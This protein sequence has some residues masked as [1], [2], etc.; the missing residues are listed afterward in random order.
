ML[1]DLSVVLDRVAG[2][3]LRVEADLPD[4]L[5]T[6]AP[7]VG[8]AVVRITQEALTNVLV[9]SG[10]AS[11]R[12]ALGV[13]GDDLELTV[14]DPGP[15]RT[16]TGPPRAGNGS[17]HMRERAQACG[18]HVTVGPLGRDGADGWQVHLV[19]PRTGRRG[20]HEVRARPPR[21]RAGAGR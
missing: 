9:H 10:A 4:P 21:A 20:E 2:A 14:S 7:D 5:P 19:V 3:G 13:H 16:P 1:D 12:V 8:L 6:C 18:G 15:A 17:V 11:T